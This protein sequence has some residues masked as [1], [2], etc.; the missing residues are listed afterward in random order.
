MRI[1]SHL[2]ARMIEGRD[3]LLAS[4]SSPEGTTIFA[5]SVRGDWYQKLVNEDCR[6]IQ[7]EGHELQRVVFACTA[8]ITSSQRDSAIAKVKNDFGWD[9]ELFGIDRLRVRL[10]GDLR[11]LIAQHPAIFCPPFFSDTWRPIDRSRSRY[12]CD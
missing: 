2:V 12:A 4:K 5:F 1:L 10:V 6:R 3:A 8:S 7:E 11:D 9:L